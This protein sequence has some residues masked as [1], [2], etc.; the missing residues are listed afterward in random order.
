[1]A[2]VIPASRPADRSCIRVRL[3]FCLVRWGSRRT[4]ACC[5]SVSFGHDPR[6]MRASLRR[7]MSSW[8]DGPTTRCFWLPGRLSARRS[9]P[10]CACRWLPPPSWPSTASRPASFRRLPRDPR[11][12]LA[13]VAVGALEVRRARQLKRHGL[14]WADASGRSLGVVPQTY[15]VL[16][17]PL[18]RRPK[19]LRRPLT[20]HRTG[21]RAGPSSA[22]AQA[23]TCRR[24]GHRTGHITDHCAGPKPHRAWQPRWRSRLRGDD[25]TVGV[26]SRIEHQRAPKVT[27]MWK[28]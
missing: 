23:L 28:E 17:S 10:C 14:R 1:M 19:R 18:L 6:T 27:E 7:P 15:R 8:R 5:W 3:R 9:R 12:A 11:G 22:A 26:R 24:T 21:H 20:C 16:H 2:A 25:C 13:R 4:R